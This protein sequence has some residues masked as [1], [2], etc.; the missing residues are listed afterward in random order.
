MRKKISLTLMFVALS[1]QPLF[2]GGSGT[3]AFQVLRIPMTAYEAAL[4]NNY[5]SDASSCVTNPAV[6]P[7]APR[8]VY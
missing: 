4:A 8:S 1:F 3:T 6:V 5:I 2:A 7:F